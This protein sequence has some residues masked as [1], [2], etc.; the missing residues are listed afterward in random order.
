[1]SGITVSRIA[2]RLGIPRKHVSSWAVAWHGSAGTG[3]RHRLDLVDVL[4]ARAWQVLG[5]AY[6]GEVSHYGRRPAAKYVRAETA[7]RSD[8]HRWLLVAGDHVHTYQR[9]EAAGWAWL[10][11][12]EPAGLVVDLWSTPR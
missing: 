8:P 10:R 11:S 3:Y 9:A 2:D 5:G 7:I 4:V 12:G 1:M 6:N